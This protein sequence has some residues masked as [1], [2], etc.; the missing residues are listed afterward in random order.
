MVATSG[1]SRSFSSFSRVALNS[2]FFRQSLVL[3]FEIEIP[4]AEDVAEG[5]GCFA[6]GVVLPFR[7]SLGDLALQTGG[8]T[9]QPS[10][11]L[12]QKLLTDARLVVETMQR[13]LR[14]DLDQVAIAF[15]IFGQDDAGGCKLSPSLSVR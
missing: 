8:Q 14:D 1:M 11:V 3:D 13:R 10:R 6:G 4:F 12:G 15:V 7:E 9:D 2:R 5:H